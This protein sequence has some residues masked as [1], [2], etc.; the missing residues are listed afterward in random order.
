MIRIA[1]FLDPLLV[2][3]ILVSVFSALTLVFLGQDEV[4]S[5]IVGLLITSITLAIDFIGRL[6]ET[7]N[8]I[9]QATAL[10]T[11]LN[12]QHELHQTIA[13][14]VKAYLSAQKSSFDL[15]QRRSRDALLECKDIL[16]GIENGYMM[17]TIFAL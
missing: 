9:L 12:E 6:K 7:E 14:I 5:L 4:S 13:E 8:K 17:V 15:F 3:G 16:R 11:L 2:I 1:K 10:G